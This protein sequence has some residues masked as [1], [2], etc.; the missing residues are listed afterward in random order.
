MDSTD[1]RIDV[2]YPTPT[3][4]Q[5]K[6]PLLS[7]AHGDSGGGAGLVTDYGI[8]LDSIAAFGYV[9][10][11]VRACNT[12]CRDDRTTLPLDPPGFGH[13]YY[14]QLRVFNWTKNETGVPFDTIDYSNGV[15][16][17]GHSMGGQATLYSSGGGHPKQYGITAAVMHHAYTHS[18]PP[19]EIPF[20]VMTGTTDKIAPA[21]PMAV[22][23]YNAK[24]AFSSRGL[25]NKR[26]ANHFEPNPN[27]YNNLLPQ[28]TAAWFKYYLDKTPKAYGINFEELIFGTGLTSVCHGG[29]GAMDECETKK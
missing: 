2:W 3:A 26:G 22:N 10:A 6:F 24:G 21:H 25:V 18:F 16:I 14:Q 15:G 4:E 29:D 27:G 19:P 12:G 7:Y 11:A 5:K 23:I 17:C 8:L 9:V 28:Y 20:L 1:H 13:Y